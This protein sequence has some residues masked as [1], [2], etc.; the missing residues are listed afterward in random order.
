VLAVVVV[1]MA[2][3]HT[4]ISFQPRT[5]IRETAIV[6]PSTGG[7]GLPTSVL[8]TFRLVTFE[9]KTAGREMDVERGSTDM[10]A[11]GSVIVEKQE[12]QVPEMARCREGGG[13]ATTGLARTNVVGLPA[14]VEESECS[15]CMHA[16][17]MNV[18]IRVLPCKHN[19]HQA[20]IDPWLVGF[21]GT[22]PVW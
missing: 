8:Q 13:I 12:L 17:N 15:I 18:K 21:S 11:P 1:L 2:V 20:C 6:H 5:T 9:A 10:K 19:F 4:I 16:F 22:C 14:R 3:A 7:K